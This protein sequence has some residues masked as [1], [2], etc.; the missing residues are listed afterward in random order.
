MNPV[1]S[2]RLKAGTL[3]CALGWWLTAGCAGYRLGPTNGLAA[4]A[5]SIQVV[6]FRNQTF[7]PRLTEAVTTALRRTLQQDGTFKLVTREDANVVLTGTLV[8]YQR[9]PVSFQARDVLTPRD[10]GAYL[11]AQ[12]TAADRVTGKKLVDQEVAASTTV[13]VGADL[14]SAER[15]AFPLLAEELA[16]QITGLLV[17]GAW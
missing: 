15:Q 1:M 4:G 16:R 12:V 10:F 3:L 8:R 11:Y 9:S 13:R 14:A 5:H 2:Q 7:E 6:P 17:D